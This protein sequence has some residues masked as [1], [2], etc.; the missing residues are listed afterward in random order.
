MTLP[1]LLDAIVWVLSGGGAGAL[2]YWLIERSGAVVD[3]P[4]RLKRPLA[5]A[6]TGLIAVGAYVGAVLMGYDQVP[7]DVFAWIEVLY[8]VVAAAILTSQLLH[9][10]QLPSAGV[11]GTPTV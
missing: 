7:P 5:F 3:I 8:S 9:V 1:S 2:A 6:F 10:R 11:G 4:P